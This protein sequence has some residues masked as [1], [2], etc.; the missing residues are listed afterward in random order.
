MAATSDTKLK[1]AQER[2]YAIMQQQLRLH[3]ASVLQMRV[4]SSMVL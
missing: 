1:P 3:A 4:C 2:F